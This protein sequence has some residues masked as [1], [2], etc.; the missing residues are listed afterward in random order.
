MNKYWWL[1]T[2]LFLIFIVSCKKRNISS[3]VVPRTDTS[4]IFPLEDLRVQ[5][6]DFTYFSF[7]SKVDYVNGKES[8]SFSVN[9]R[10]KKDSVIWLSVSPGLGI[11]AV[12]CLIL[13]DS[14]LILDRINNKLHAYGFSFIN[15]ALKTTLTF[16]NLQA[17]LLGNLA[18]KSASGDQLLQQGDTGYWLLK[19]GRGELQADN[20]IL[21]RTLKIEGLE[22]NNLE[23]NTY[24]SLKYANFAPLDSFLFANHIKTVVKFADEQGVERNTQ[25]DIQHSK[26]EIVT[27]PL[28]FPFNVP[29]RFDE[30]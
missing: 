9:G 24:L 6:I 11:E 2:A 1:G 10:I 14:V 30:K 27:K 4:H 15:N 18:F 12:R 5:E 21:G 8:Q 29:K 19:Q 13:K 23:N 22:V 28:N 20:Y 16:E 25:I 17:L 3:S 7:K 26:A